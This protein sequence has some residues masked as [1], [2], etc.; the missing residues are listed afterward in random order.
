MKG[1][2]KKKNKKES[3]EEQSLKDVITVFTYLVQQ[4]KAIT[5]IQ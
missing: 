2:A 3:E 5:L 1:Y 4:R